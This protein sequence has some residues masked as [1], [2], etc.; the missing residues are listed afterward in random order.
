MFAFTSKSFAFFARNSHF[1]SIITYFSNFVFAVLLKNLE[2]Y[3]QLYKKNL[4]FSYQHNN[5]QELENSLQRE[6]K[7]KYPS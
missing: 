6:R 5:Q 1:F 3:I 7:K 4:K 2:N